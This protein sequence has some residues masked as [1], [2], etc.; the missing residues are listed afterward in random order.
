MNSYNHRLYS[1]KKDGIEMRFEP[2]PIDTTVSQ[3]NVLPTT[4][5]RPTISDGIFLIT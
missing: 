1:L 4:L 3:N 2:I 5:T